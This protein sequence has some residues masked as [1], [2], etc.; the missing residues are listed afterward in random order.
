MSE[1]GSR[2]KNASVS[3][4]NMLAAGTALAATTLVGATAAAQAQVAPGRR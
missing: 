3:R 1:Q 2:D 4:R